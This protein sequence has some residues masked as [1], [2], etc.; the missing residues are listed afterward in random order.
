MV[1][2]L[3]AFLALLTGFAA[4]NAP[5]QAAVASAASVTVE[6]ADDTQQTARRDDTAC[7]QRQA[8]QR[9]AGQT[10]TPCKGQ[11]PVVIYLPSVHL[12]PDRARE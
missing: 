1:R 8:K 3:L 7:A 9:R 4:L 6:R 12:G 2:Q 10:V 5:V 11:T